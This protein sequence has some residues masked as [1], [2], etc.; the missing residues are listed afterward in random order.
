MNDPVKGCDVYKNIG[1]AHVDGFLCDYPNCSILKE[2]KMNE[3]IKQLAEQAGFR[4]NPD[5]YDRNQS[6]DIN[7]FAEL[8]VRECLSIVEPTQHHQ[9]FAPSYLGDVEGLELLENKVTQIK[10]HFGV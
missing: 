3:R 7:K 6:F 5:I 10:K 1:C 8:I 2:Y 9:A 4:S